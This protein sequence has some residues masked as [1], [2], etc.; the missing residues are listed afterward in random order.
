MLGLLL[1]STSGNPKVYNACTIVPNGNYYS[2]PE[3]A[4]TSA[5]WHLFKDCHFYHMNFHTSVSGTALKENRCCRVCCNVTFTLGRY[6][7][8]SLFDQ[9]APY[10]FPCGPNKI[11]DRHQVCIKKP[12]EIVEIE[13]TTERNNVFVNETF[14]Y[15]DEVYEEQLNK[16]RYLAY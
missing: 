6:T 11:C 9:H 1:K 8:Y 3:A 13:E 10:G 4:N 12:N 5:E 15:S 7:R 2:N 16:R 14:W